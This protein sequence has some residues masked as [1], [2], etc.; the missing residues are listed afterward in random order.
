MSSLIAYGEGYGIGDSAMARTVGLPVA[1][2]ARLI[3]D[4]MLVQVQ[5]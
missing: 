5:T 1:I 4:G 3:I 2:A